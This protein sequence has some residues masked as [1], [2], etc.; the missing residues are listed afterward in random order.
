MIG[1][2]ALL[3][4]VLPIGAEFDISQGVAHPMGGV[5]AS[6]PT[7]GQ[8][9]TTGTL[10]AGPYAVNFTALGLP[11]G[12]TWTV[13]L[14]GSI[15]GSNTSTVH[16]DTANGSYS[17]E[18][19]DPPGY[20]SSPSSGLINVTGQNVSQV[21]DFPRL[22]QVTFQETGLPVN[23]LWSVMLGHSVQSSTGSAVYFNETQGSYDYQVT[24]PAGYVPSPSS[25]T[26]TLPGS[27]RSGDVWINISWTVKTYSVTFY[28]SG[29]PHNT[30]WT[31]DF[32][33]TAYS[34]NG[35]SLAVYPPVPNGSYPYS[36][37]GP[38]TYRAVPSSGTVNVSG[39]SGSRS[40]Q[41]LHLWT[42]SFTETGLPS[43]RAWN[44]TLNQT[45]HSSTG[46]TIYFNETN[47]TY[48]P[49]TVGLESGYSANQT[50]GYVNVS[51]PGTVQSI[52]WSP[53]RYTLT[54]SESGLPTGTN[55]TVNL[56]HAT[57]TV[58]SPGTILFSVANGTFS[59]S[60]LNLSGYSPQPEYGTVTISGSSRSVAI[61]F[62]PTYDVTFTE[63]GLPAGTAWSVALGGN[64][65]SG[66]TSSLVI[67]ELSGQYNYRIGAIPGY[68]A[69]PSSGSVNV[70]G[71]PVTVSITWKVVNYLVTFVE[72]G[73]PAG[74]GWS[75][76]FG[77]THQLGVSSN[78]T[79]TFVAPNGTYP[80]AVATVSGLVPTPENGTVN[81]TGSS[82]TQS[83]TFRAQATYNVSFTE[84]GLPSGTN[85]TV[86]VEAVELAST[87]PTIVF[88]EANG[89]YSYQ[90]GAIAGY[91][92]SQN[93]SGIVSV[94]GTDLTFHVA[95]ASIPYPVSFIEHG[96]PGGTNWSV[97]LSGAVQSST[98]N[99]IRFLLPNG[100]YTFSVASQSGYFASPDTGGL[101]VNGTAIVQYV[102]WSRYSY[103]VAFMAN[104][105]PSNTTWSVTLAGQTLSTNGT[106]IDFSEPNASYNYR[107]GV[108]QDFWTGAGTGRGSVNVNGSG[109]TVPL[110]FVPFTYPVTFKEYSFSSGPNWTVTIAGGSFSTST[111]SLIVQLPN[112]T[113]PYTVSVAGS[114]WVPSPSTGVMNVTGHTNYTT[115]HFTPLSGSGGH[116]ITFTLFDEELLAVTLVI[117]LLLALLGFVVRPLNRKHRTGPNPLMPPPDEASRP[118]GPPA[119]SA[120]GAAV[121]RAIPPGTELAPTPENSAALLRLAVAIG[122]VVAQQKEPQ[123]T[124][125]NLELRR[126]MDLIESYRLTEAMRV[127]GRLR[128]EVTSAVAAHPAEPAVVAP[129]PSKPPSGPARS[130]K[131]RGTRWAN[132]TVLTASHASR[133]GASATNES[134]DPAP[135]DG[136]IPISGVG[137]SL[138]TWRAHPHRTP[139]RRE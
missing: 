98:T 116:P 38:S 2:V 29:L 41:F 60:V 21:I 63:S 66:S 10:P 9:A 124:A 27:S 12:V 90:V 125:W 22:Y 6:G 80:F 4:L 75:V 127:L 48:Y 87:G 81:V 34:T 136:E 36:V 15:N 35:S 37:T 43:G 28:E 132:P 31:V 123:V 95:F 7:H 19:G 42:V 39:S 76:T 14:N 113:Y 92:V 86:T 3:L 13:N 57:G 69:T 47:G 122:R 65:A 62:L 114:S 112:G 110:Y 46:S 111:T 59:Y 79:I 134:G 54:F 44:V 61:T 88:L 74:Y 94:Q 139:P 11:A 107:L 77:P 115:L 96:L 20:I 18:I 83:V 91:T 72:A 16:F 71:G 135:S 24:G 5:A 129:S 118:G 93:A 26:V 23:S 105:L 53:V 17:F 51:G 133:S 70:T 108:V 67:P 68:L 89:T 33:G 49:F 102:N 40:I 131:P 97:N 104:D 138:E 109:V 64:A 137:A 126:A 101:L 117:V 84:T 85:W 8:V 99:T 30:N 120:P 100:S 130:K 73:L 106:E 50:A 119:G 82:V 1:V 45:T 52:A 32:N 121:A 78:S 103:L 128:T 55:W 56:A 25:G 58:Q